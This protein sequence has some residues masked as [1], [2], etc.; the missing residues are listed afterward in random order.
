M[1]TQ[2]HDFCS[3]RP[4]GANPEYVML[5]DADIERYLQVLKEEGLSPS[6][7]TRYHG[8]LQKLQAY[9]GSERK[10]TKTTL[11]KWQNSMKESGYASRSIIARLSAVNNFLSFMGWND[12]RLAPPPASD[13]EMPS[14]SQKEYQQMLKVACEQQDRKG[15]LILRLFA[16]V[17][18]L[19]RQFYLVT[20]EAV[21]EGFVRSKKG[22]QSCI[23]AFNWLLQHDLLSYAQSN[24]ITQGCIF[25]NRKG[26][27]LT[28]EAII[29]ELS[30]IAAKAGVER[31]KVTL[32]NLQRLNKG[33]AVAA[34]AL[35]KLQQDENVSNAVVTAM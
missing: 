29:A 33:M 2:E 28:P 5:E 4:S 8:D 12:L 15:E 7:L 26:L 10:I 20:V 11:S 34:S 16:E 19:R 31:D 22:H 21:M 35:L 17:G 3:S 9:I 6:T 23:I 32:R 1:G 30:S 14:L 13:N 18:I 24:G 25:L 27:P